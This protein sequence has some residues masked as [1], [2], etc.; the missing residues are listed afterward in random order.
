MFENL[1]VLALAVWEFVEIWHHSDLVADWRS[2]TELWEGPIGRMLRC[3]FCMTPWA[4]LFLFLSA[5]EIVYLGVSIVAAIGAVLL[6]LGG[7]LKT[8]WLLW[9][10]IALLSQ[11]GIYYQTFDTHLLLLAVA[12]L[13]NL[14][15]DLSHRWCRTPKPNFQNPHFESE[16][17]AAPENV[18]TVPDTFIVGPDGQGTPDVRPAGAGGASA[19]LRADLPQ[20]P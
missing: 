18:S 5:S 20:S 15:N 3:P 2:R 4:A 17:H 11:V 9:A 19:G 16:T 10:A 13:A 12:R 6:F 14:G 1:I 7:P 8:R